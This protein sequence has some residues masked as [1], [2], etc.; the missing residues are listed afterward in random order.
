M[1]DS[2]DGVQSFHAL[3]NKAYSRDRGLV[4]LLTTA[5][6]ILLL[7]TAGGIIG[8]TVFWVDQR[9]RQIGLR[10]ALGARRSDILA[11]ILTENFFIIL[12]GI[13]VGSLLAFATNVA[14]MHFLEMTRLPSTYIALGSAVLLVLGQCAALTPARRAALMSPMEAT[15]AAI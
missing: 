1:I 7:A 13:G 12:L 15:R 11:H 14:L 9:R 2:V 8:M 10:R 6:I 3:R 4:M 5:S